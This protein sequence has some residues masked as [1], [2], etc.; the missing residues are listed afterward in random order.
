MG[1]ASR[2]PLR[3]SHLSR[4]LPDEKE[5]QPCE[6]QGSLLKMEGIQ[7]PP[8]QGRGRGTDSEPREEWP[9]MK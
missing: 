5:P 9:K 4:H 1:A 2:A 8:R 3:K 6:K 7:K